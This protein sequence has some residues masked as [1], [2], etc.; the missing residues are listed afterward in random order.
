MGERSQKSKDT[1][2][3]IQSVLK[4]SFDKESRN[5]SE[6]KNLVWN[7]ATYWKKNQK[8]VLTGD[9]TLLAESS[10]NSI[11]Q[12]MSRIKLKGSGRPKKKACHKNPFDIGKCKLWQRNRLNEGRRVNH[13]TMDSSLVPNY[14]NQNG[15]EAKK[16][17][18]LAGKL[19]LKARMGTEIMEETIRR[20][21]N[22]GNI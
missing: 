12:L 15:E 22:T 5:N 10:Q 17:L 11:C 2:Q 1:K 6:K 16:I 18:E 14:K 21:M 9:T 7:Y 4:N 19:R 20:R 8:V 3:K 13:I